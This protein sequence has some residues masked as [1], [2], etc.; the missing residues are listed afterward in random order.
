MNRNMILG[1]H[2]YTIGIIRWFLLHDRKWVPFIFCMDHIIPHDKK[3]TGFWENCNNFDHLHLKN[4]NLFIWNGVNILVS[5]IVLRPI[6]YRLK[7]NG[8]Y[9]SYRLYLDIRMMFYSDVLFWCSIL[10]LISEIGD[11]K[12]LFKFLILFHLTCI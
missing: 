10:M 3:N 4:D 2:R 1:I 6:I 7:Y 11:K 8:F 5:L 12:S 9:P